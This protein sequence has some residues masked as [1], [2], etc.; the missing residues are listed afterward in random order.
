[1]ETPSFEAKKVQIAYPVYAGLL[2]LLVGLTAEKAQESLDQVRKVFDTVDAR[3][4]A[5]KD[6]LVGDRFTLSDITFA[7][8]A[9]TVVLPNNYGGPLPSFDQ[10]P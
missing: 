5:R 6:Y 8:A 7:V 2:R 4:S 3:L 10:M 9:A 1:L